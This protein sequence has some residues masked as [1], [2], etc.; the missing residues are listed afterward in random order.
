MATV[1]PPARNVRLFRLYC[2]VAAFL[3]AGFTVYPVITKLVDHRLA[4]DWVHSALHLLFCLLAVYAGWFAR[5]VWAARWFTVTVGAA[6]GVL[7]V[8]G[9]FVPGLLL[10]TPVAIPLDPVANVFHLVLAVPAILLVA[11][12]GGRARDERTPPRG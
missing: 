9:W 1:A 12:S 5:D 10:G 3:F 2:R 4:H 7:G 8:V 11:A 6:Y